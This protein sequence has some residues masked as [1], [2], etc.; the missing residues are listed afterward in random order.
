MKP[1]NESLYDYSRVFSSIPANSL[2]SSL[3][4]KGYNLFKEYF[5]SGI[6]QDKVG[7]FIFL[8][9]NERINSTN[10]IDNVPDLNPALDDYE[11][12]LNTIIEIINENNASI[13]FATHPYLWK[14]NMTKEE[15]SVLWM[16]T[17]FNNNFYTVPIMKESLNKFNIKLIKVCNENNI[18]C[19]DLEKK[20]LKSLEYFYDDM[21]FNERGSAFVA[22]KFVEFLRNNFE[23]F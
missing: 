2:E 16:T 4:F 19:L 8:S 7:N 1:F 6:K 12:N 10:I 3:A 11:Q 20:V 17:D 14:D 5:N 9:R 23:E 22:D 18:L 15:D 13:L 21:H